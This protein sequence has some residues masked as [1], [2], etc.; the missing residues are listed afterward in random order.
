MTQ[1]TL[2]QIRTQ[3]RKYSPYT[4]AKNFL[5]YLKDAEQPVTAKNACFCIEGVFCQAAIDLG[6][7]AK[8]KADDD[9]EVHLEDLPDATG[10]EVLMDF[11]RPSSQ[12][13]M[14]SAAPSEVYRFLGLPRFIT[15][16]DLVDLGVKKEDLDKTL[17][18][19]RLNGTGSINWFVANDVTEI[20]LHDL[21]SLACKLVSTENQ[22]APKDDD[23]ETDA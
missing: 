4:K 15:K 9:Y 3:L 6:L 13:K 17:D 7:D 19:I 5:F 16:K 11:V 8:F 20:P 14:K 23:E 18:H 22:L 2:D 12:F 1:P 10:K 21:I